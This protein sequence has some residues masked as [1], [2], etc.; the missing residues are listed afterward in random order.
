VGLGERPLGGSARRHHRLGGRL[1]GAA[2]QGIRVGKRPLEIAEVR[3]Q[4]SQIAQ[5]LQEKLK[6]MNLEIV[7][8]NLKSGSQKLHR[9]HPVRRLV[10]CFRHSQWRSCLA[11]SLVILGSTLAVTTAN[12]QIT[13][14]LPLAPATRLESLETNIAVIVIKTSAAEG[15]LSVDG[16]TITVSS[17]EMTDASTGRKEQGVAIEITQRERIKNTTLLDY[18]ELVPLLNAIN[19]LRQMEVPETD[20][21]TFDAT[22]TTKGGLRIAAFGG[23]R[24]GAV[25][26]SIRDVRLGTTAVMLSRDDLLRFA[27]FLN[28]A[29][30]RLDSLRGH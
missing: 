26:Y 15:S 2:R 22:F 1:L 21:N 5:M 14:P 11:T 25:R 17:R 16:G 6:I 27:G 24:T 28:Q 23:R 8:K 19:Y 29:K 9:V 20:L 7:M 13:N 10:D 30:A 12:A 18:D 4:V 3:P